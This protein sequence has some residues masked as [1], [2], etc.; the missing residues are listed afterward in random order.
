MNRLADVRS[1]SSPSEAEVAAHLA[2]LEERVFQVNTRWPHF[3]LLLGDLKRLAKELPETATVVSLERTLLYGGISLFAPLFT[4]Q[5]FVSVD[6]SPAAADERG[7]YNASMLDDAR[8]IRIPYSIRGSELETGLP[9]ESAD[10][11]LVPNL[12]HHVAEQERLFDEMTRITRRDGRVY[13]FEPLLREL[14]QIPEDYLRYTPY[15]LQRVMEARG[16]TV[17]MTELEGGPFSAAAYCW[18]QALQ[19]L[20]PTKRE[21]MQRWFD[22]EMFPNLIQW[23]EQYPVNLVRKHTSFPVSFSLLA[24]KG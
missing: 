7:A 24:R 19:Y 8:V 18:D 17:E 3:R 10:L 14:H 22:T 12:V 23:D 11:V 21:E 16:L 2:M 5:M 1:Q 9:D 13:V 4:R 15:G 6:C 20:P